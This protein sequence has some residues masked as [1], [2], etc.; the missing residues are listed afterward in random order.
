MRVAILVFPGSNCEQ[1]IGYAC[2]YL[3]I[4]FSYVWHQEHSLEGFDAVMLPGGF[5]YGDYLRCGA[6]A[7][8]SPIM[9]EVCRFARVGHPVIGICNGFQILTEAHLLPGA[10]LRNRD[11]KFICRDVPLKVCASCVWLDMPPGSVIHLPIN[12]NEGNFV[13]D[14]HTLESLQEHEQII[15][16]YCAEDGGEIACAPNGALDNIAGITN[17][18]RNVCGLMPHPERAV[19]P[20]VGR[21]DGQAFFTTV[22]SRLSREVA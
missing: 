3:G 7:R 10:L 6:V 5:S 17:V 1:D 16:R 15:M 4:D 12:H 13:C 11:L 8:F 2:T 19:D 22:L 18:G 14:K 9:E 20:V 21:T